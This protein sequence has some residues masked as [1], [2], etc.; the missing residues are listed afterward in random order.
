M[1]NTEYIMTSEKEARTGNTGLS[2]LAVQYSADSLVVNESLVLRINIC[3]EN[4][5][6]RQARNRY[7]SPAEITQIFK[8]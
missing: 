2:K 1:R 3:G 5:H 7:W 4:R 6:L 8:I